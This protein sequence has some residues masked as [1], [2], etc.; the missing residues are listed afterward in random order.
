MPYDTHVAAV[1]IGLERLGASAYNWVTSD[2]P[3]FA[4]S[5]IHI[6][7]PK[8]VPRVRVTHEGVTTDLHQFDVI[9]NR[10][11][12]RPL[13]PE[14]ASPHDAPV[15]EEECLLHTESMLFLLSKLVRTVNDPFAQR[16]ADRKAVQLHF[17]AS[18]GLKTVPTLFSNDVAEISDFYDMHAPLVAKPHRQHGWRDE[19]KT[20][21]ELTFDMPPPRTLDP[22]SIE[23]CPLILQKKIVRVMEVRVIAFGGKVYAMRT[24]D[25]AGRLDARFESLVKGFDSFTVVDIPRDVAE[26][27]NK[28]L[29]GMAI[30]FGAFDFIID[31]A[32]DWFFL[33]CNESGQFLYLEE[34]VP[35]LRLLDGFCRWLIEIGGGLVPDDAEELCLAEV[36]SSNAM[37]SYNTDRLTHKNVSSLHLIVESVA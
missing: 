5:T 8:A 33:E 32:G 27:C 36:M 21:N 18:I 35:E 25:E 20:Y 23:L 7:G 31:K 4:T 24:V 34:K 16:R 22:K 30:E 9:W 26:L 14:G 6:P 11:R 15:I 2:L 3:D 28:Y 10:R 1:R 12:E 29:R 13:A 17:A 19:K 37:L